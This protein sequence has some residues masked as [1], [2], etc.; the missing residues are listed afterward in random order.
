MHSTSPL[1]TVKYAVMVV[2]VPGVYS[3]CVLHPAFPTTSGAE[4]KDDAHFIPN[5]LWSRVAS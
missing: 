1:N 3:S 5:R 2:N 4:A